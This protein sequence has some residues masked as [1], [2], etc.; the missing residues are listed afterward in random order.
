[1]S[2]F[3]VSSPL[4]FFRRLKARFSR[5]KADLAGATAIR[6]ILALAQK[7]GR[8]DVSNMAASIAYFA[9]LSL[10]PLILSMLAIFGL[11]LPSESVQ[12]HLINFFSQSLP[13]SASILQN[14]IPDIIRFRST[15]GIIGIL[16]LI[17]SGSGVFSAITH[18]INRAWDIKFE[19]PFYIKKPKEI[20][21][22]LGTG[23][24]FL[25][26]FIT[27]AFFSVLGSLRLP[28]TGALVTIL[29]AV[30]AL[31]FSLMIF[32][33]VHKVSPII[34][35]SWRHVWPGAIL[36]TVFFE[37]AKSGF[38]FYLNHFNHYDKIYGSIASVIMLLV[39]IYLSAYILLLGAEFSSLLFR[40]K[41]EGEQFDKPARKPDLIKEIQEN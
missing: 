4:F 34:W 31:I 41:R 16:G 9:I 7:I 8:D 10:F 27:S 2:S 22:V 39:W 12:Q 38:V 13:G 26:S 35:V 33:I 21:M 28:V 15:F 18:S 36:S 24:L 40:V 14:N 25:L 3:E 29:T 1:M 37:I 19:H 32:L 23:A 6:F 11:F 30:A 17:W 5:L 20:G